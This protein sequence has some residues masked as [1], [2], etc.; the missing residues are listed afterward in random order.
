MKRLLLALSLLSAA[1]GPVSAHDDEGRAASSEHRVEAPSWLLSPAGSGTWLENGARRAWADVRVANVRYDKRVFAEVVAHY[2]GGATITTLHP[3]T[4]KGALGQGEKWGV[5][6]IAIQEQG[7]KGARRTGEVS[8]RFRLQHDVDGRDQM[9]ETAW[10]HLYG[11]GTTPIESDPW[12]PGLTSPVHAG[13]THA[14]EI[15][16]APFDDPGGMILREIDA[17]IAAKQKDPSGRHT[18]HA[19]IF[20]IDDP[21]IVQRLIAAHRAGVEVRLI[22]D[23][24]RFDP[25]LT[26]NTGDDELL[27]AGVPLLGLAHPGAMHLKLAVFDGKKVTTGSAN[28]EHGSSFENHEDLVLLD[29]PAIVAAYAQRFERLAGMAMGA[30]V[31]SRDVSF[32]PDEAPQRR[33]GALVDGA[34]SSIH[35]AMFTAKDFRYDDGQSLFDK[36]VAA[37]RRGVEVTLVTDRGVAEGDEYFGVT[38][39]DDQTDERLEAEGITVVRAKVPFARYAS[40]H[41]KFAVFDRETTAFGAY[42]WYWDATFLNDEDVVFVHDRAFA[43]R[44]DGEMAELCRR[45]DPKFDPANW[46]SVQVTLRASH[47]GTAWG[48]SVLAI[49]DVDA[50]G[51]WSPVKGLPLSGWPV[52]TGTVTLPAG[53]RVAWKLATR[54]ADGSTSWESGDNRLLTV[55]TGATAQIVEA[56]YR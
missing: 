23:A 22:T 16:F 19:A 28:W 49:G 24:K 54:R 53:A 20:D 48:D 36:L 51:A 11:E 5:D 4:Y 38:T 39:P 25:K 13:E 8:I 40:M 34:R 27:A 45:Y 26:W 30:R 1:C 14:P 29:D 33:L 3:A 52:W 46:P 47:P 10:T 31:G 15:R 55:L 32:G 37:R 7:P 6:T 12:A 2:E 18:L 41:H 56:S 42:N 9:V 35:L 17:V 43:A 44:F 21:R 50:L